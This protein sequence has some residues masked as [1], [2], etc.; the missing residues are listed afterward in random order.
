M[1]RPAVVAAARAALA[2]GVVAVVSPDSV[3]PAGKTQQGEGAKQGAVVIVAKASKAC[4]SASV[5]VT[6]FLVPR[7]EA[8]VTLDMDGYRITEIMA[9]EGDEI[10][11]GQNLVRL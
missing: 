5:Q 10:S 7:R 9:K 1:K 8:L 6:G 2:I 11:A 3:V 4:F